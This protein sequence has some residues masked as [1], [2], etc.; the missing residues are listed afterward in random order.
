M[1]IRISTLFALG[2]LIVSVSAIWLVESLRARPFEHP[3]PVVIAP[4]GPYKL[5]AMRPLAPY[6]AFRVFER[7]PGGKHI[8]EKIT[9]APDSETPIPPRKR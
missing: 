7:L 1:G 2:S 8:P 6:D 4:D 5:K 3:V 9:I